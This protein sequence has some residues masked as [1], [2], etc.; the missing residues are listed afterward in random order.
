MLTP[1]QAAQ[2]LGIRTTTLYGWLGLAR[3]GELV[4]RGERFALQFLQTGPRGQGR[5]LIAESEVDRLRE[6]LVVRPRPVF[7]RK[8]PTPRTNFP[9]IHVPL[10]R[11]DQPSG[12]RARPK[13]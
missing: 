8:P 9:G 7:T 13:S 12:T 2:R 5:I 10:G 4:L 3:I 1:R 11:P 6:H